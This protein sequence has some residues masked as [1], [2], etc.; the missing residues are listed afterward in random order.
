MLPGFSGHLISES[1]L[2]R[3]LS[4]EPR[5][6]ES[7]DL[8]RHRLAICR[9]RSQS[10]GPAS[11]LRALLEEGAAPFVREL[12]FGD[13]AD[14]EALKDSLV[15]TISSGSGPVAL[16]V[17]SWGLRLESLWRAGVVH[18]RRRGA[19][20]CLFFNGIHARLIDASRLYS[21][22]HVQF[23][24][25]V[26]LDD[27]RASAALLTVL[28]AAS[29]SIVEGHRESMLHRL[30]ESSERDAAE[31]RRTLRH[32]VLQAAVDVLGTLMVRRRP[33]AIDNAFEQERSS[34]NREAGGRHLRRPTTP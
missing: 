24:L 18:A 11:S 8:L 25:D 12:G 1:F 34:A 4:E 31:V 9:G 3:L 23:D 10:L 2:E 16:V 32:G 30:V 27:A 26:A 22:R 14:V 20:W 6:G 21:R 5:L 7:S 13:P 19:A 17:A 29:F 28:R 33:P 15:A